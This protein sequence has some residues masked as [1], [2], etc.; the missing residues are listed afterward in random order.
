MYTRQILDVYSVTGKHVSTTTS[1]CT[2][3]LANLIK[4]PCSF[5]ICACSDVVVCVWVR[6]RMSSHSQLKVLIHIST[7]TCTCSLAH[8]ANVQFALPLSNWSCSI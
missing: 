5:C 3:Q 7:C 2:W 6:N 4:S 1:T 8:L